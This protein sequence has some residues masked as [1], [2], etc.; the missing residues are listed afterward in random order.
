MMAIASAL[1]L[2]LIALVHEPRGLARAA[3][4]QVPG[5][6]ATIESAT[7]RGGG[8]YNDLANPSVDGCVFLENFAKRWAAECTTTWAWP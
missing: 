3:V 1:A 8:M 6:H 7:D 5:D 2:V 4:I